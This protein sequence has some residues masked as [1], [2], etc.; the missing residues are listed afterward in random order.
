MDID[1]NTAQCIDRIG[2][3]SKSD[4]NK[5]CDIHIQVHIQHIDRLFRTTLC[6]CCITL[7][8]RIIS[9]IQVSITVNR[10]QLTLSRI[11]IDGCDHDGIASRL[12]VKLSFPG[13]NTKQGNITIALHSRLFLLLD[14][15]IDHDILFRNIYLS[16]LF[17]LQYT[18]KNKYHHKQ[19]Q[20]LY[21]KEYDL[22]ALILILLFLFMMSTAIRSM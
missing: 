6:I 7:I 2:Q 4:S 10:H 16:Y 11:L 15:F 19:D 1:L 18:V 9:Q 20:D 13:V 22:S 12:L 8:I 3:S 21:N 14:L 5:V 17:C